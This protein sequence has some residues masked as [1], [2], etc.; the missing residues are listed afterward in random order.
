MIVSRPRKMDPRTELVR[1]VVKPRVA[2]RR[3]WALLGWTR[4]DNPL[5]SGNDSP[6]SVSRGRNLKEEWINDKT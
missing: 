3:A 2:T 5:R 6:R 1:P 4:P